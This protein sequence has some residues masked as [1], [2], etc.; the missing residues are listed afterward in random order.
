MV[1]E[2]LGFLFLIKKNFVKIVKI[3]I[4]QSPNTQEF[5]QNLITGFIAP[6]KKIKLNDARFC[7][8]VCY[9]PL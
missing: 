1:N 2:F 9:Q 7:A 4:F 5:I 3:S 6:Q 8:N